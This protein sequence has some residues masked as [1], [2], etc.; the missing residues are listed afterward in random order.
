[1]EGIIIRTNNERLPLIN[2]GT[3][4]RSLETS[5][6]PE[7]AIMQTCV[8]LTDFFGATALGPQDMYFI[9]WPLVSEYTVAF[10][11]QAKLEL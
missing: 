7:L 5:M 8:A 10:P 4:Y 9:Q 2:R 11:E 1:M 3:D 6:S